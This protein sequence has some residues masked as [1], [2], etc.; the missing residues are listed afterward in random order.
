[1]AE[2]ASAY[3][4]QRLGTG[5]GEVEPL[6][7]G[8]VLHVGRSP[9]N[10]LVLKDDLSSRDHAELYFAE[11]RW[12]LRD[13]ESL[14]GTKL[15]G[16][17]VHGDVS[18][19]EGDEIL[20]GQS[21]FSFVENLNNL[22]GY[23]PET[24]LMSSPETDK[25]T[26][27]QPSTKYH[28]IPDQLQKLSENY[29]EKKDTI[30][31]LGIL[32]RLGVDMGK[33]TTLEELV[34]FVLKGLM[35][36]VPAEVG[37][38]LSVK[39]SRSQELIAYQHR[40]ANAKNYHKVSQFVTEEVLSHKSAIIAQSVNT[41]PRYKHRDS[42]AD[43]KVLSLIC[44]PVIFEEKV[45]GLIHLYST[46]AST[47]HSEHLFFT[48]AVAGQLGIAWHQ[49]KRQQALSSMNR[50]LRDTLKL[51]SE[52][53]GSSPALK[54]ILGQVA[55]VA[56]TNATV[57]IR[58]ESGSGKELIARAIHFNSPRKEGPLVCLNCAAITE[59]LIESELFGHERGAFTGATE[60]MIGKFEAADHGTIFLDEIGE[61]PLSTQS[62]FLRVLEGHS[63]ERLGGNNQ[64]RVDVRVVAATNRDLED[65]VRQGS[66][67]RDLFFRLQVIEFQ[68]PPLRDR[69]TDIPELADYFLKRF[70]K[71]VGRKI[72]GFTPGALQK[73]QTY[74]WPGNVRELKNVIERC[75]ALS[76]GPIIDASDIWLSS[77][78]LKP[79]TSVIAAYEPL[80]IEELERRHI[81]ATLEHTQW[82]KSQA[83]GILAIERSTLDR[84]IKS[85]NIKRESDD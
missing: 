39:D 55:R 19:T 6:Y 61:M 17:R 44:A 15:N 66:F 68:V 22:P 10:D 18:L 65:A 79:S 41:D 47:L 78:D 33:A 36:G 5:F 23:V 56:E 9:K 11:D 60:K 16:E 73:L 64:I 59:S 31:G 75:V 37:A 76:S 72:K 63:F 20:F 69:L 25:I 84:K 26:I 30:L 80:S 49:L 8:S 2:K 42:I 7:A 81:M 40:H 43:L 21:H 70:T 71:E 32:Y 13:L 12:Y 77:L 74:H 29:P 67:R 82:N 53:V 3:L 27:S 58:G 1:M 62:K 24:V 38:V 54:S 14:N 85:Y 48:Q 4:V 51:E 46:G 57:L 52:L 50:E 34:G 28:L 35:E 83:A 45:L